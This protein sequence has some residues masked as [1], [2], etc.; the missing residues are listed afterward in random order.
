VLQD[1]KEKGLFPMTFAVYTGNE[2]FYSDSG[3]GRAGGSG[4]WHVVNVMDYNAG[5]PPT[6]SVDNTWGAGAD[7]L[8]SDNQVSLHDLYQSLRENS[9]GGGSDNSELLQIIGTGALFYIGV[10]GTEAAVSMA[11]KQLA[12]F[13]GRNKESA[14]P[15]QKMEG[16]G[17][18]PPKPTEPA[19]RG[20]EPGAAEAETH[21]RHPVR[22]GAVRLEAHE[23]L[24]ANADG[25][26][27]KGVE[28]PGNYKVGADSAVDADLLAKSKEALKA[29][30]EEL[31]KL[32]EQGKLDKQ[33]TSELR[34]IR[35]TQALLNYSKTKAEAE[36][37][38]LDALQKASEGKLQLPESP[39][40]KPIET[41]RSRLSTGRIVIY[42]AIAS[43]IMGG[44]IY[45]AAR[46]NRPA[47]IP[48]A[49]PVEGR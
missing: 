22:R 41:E 44:V 21:P 26:F 40:F 45:L 23:T 30:E 4:G 34:D 20:A 10:K 42:A 8:K 39:E 18:T 28:I 25:T 36:A 24:T 46:N 29:R 5:P 32:E 27:H 9:R 17:S 47:P 49:A 43:A 6:V 33:Q 31:A 14:A 11:R 37:T 2:P 7:H 19:D 35:N 3:A 13:S 16:E 38:M 12:K 1:A 48:N 15:D